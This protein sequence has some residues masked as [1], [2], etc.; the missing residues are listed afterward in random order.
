MGI[1]AKRLLAEPLEELGELRLHL[2]E[3]RLCVVAFGARHLEL[4]E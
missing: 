1:L 3:L 2:G 4:E